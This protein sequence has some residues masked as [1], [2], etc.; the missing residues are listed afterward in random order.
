M[1]KTLQATTS[2]VL[3]ALRPFIVPGRPQIA[4]LAAA[5]AQCPTPEV[6]K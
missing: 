2:G 3:A 5:R 6:V 1:N 4:T